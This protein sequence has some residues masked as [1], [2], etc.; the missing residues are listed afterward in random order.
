M[1]RSKWSDD[2][3]AFEGLASMT[4]RAEELFGIPNTPIDD[5]GGFVAPIFPMREVVLFPRMI[6][7]VFFAGDAELQVVEVAQQIKQTIIV[8]FPKDPKKKTYSRKTDF[9]PIS[10]E[11]ASGSVVSLPD[12]HYS[13]LLQ[14]RR[15]VKIL[16]TRKQDGFHLAYCCPIDDEVK[17]TNAMKGLIRST[18][19]LFERVVSLDRKLPD[20]SYGLA[21]SIDDPI[22]LADMIMTTVTIPRQDRLAILQEADPVKRLNLVNRALAAELSILEVES[23]ISEKVQDEVDKSQREFYLREQVKA[24]QKELNEED[25]FTRETEELRAKVAEKGFP[26]AVL[27]VAEREVD[28]LAA[29]PPMS[30]EITVSRT[31]LDWLLD[32]PWTETTEDN[33][34]VRNA[35]RVLNE[36]H[37]GLKKA[38]DRILEYIAVRS[39]KPK[40]ER[41]PILC[42]VGPPGTGKTSIGRSIADALG[43]E[44]V[45]ISLGG[46][47]DEAE[48]RGHRKTYVGALPGR[49]LQTIKRAG[50]I[51][52]LFMLD[53]IDKLGND[54]RGDPASALLEVLDPEQNNTFADHYLEVEYD[55]SK[56]MFVTTANSQDAI[57][58]PLL[59]RMEVIEFP[60]YTPEEKLIIAKDYLIGRQFDENG[61]DAN[62]L[63]LSD[64]AIRKLIREYT[65]EAGVRNLEREI[66]KICRKIARM[67][68]EKRAFP[69]VIDPDQVETL[70][71]PP[72]FFDSEKERQ[73]QVGVAT[74]LAWTE[75]GG[76]LTTIEALCFE[77]K[78]SLQLTGQLGEVMQESAQAALSYIKANTQRFNIPIS[79]YEKMDLHIHVPEGAV[80]KDGPSGGITLATAM[81]SALTNTPIRRD[82]AMT[83]EITLRGHVLP[84][85]GLKEKS[86]AALR[87]G[88]TTV[89]I[90]EKNLKDLVE[91]SKEALE[92]LTFIGVSTMDEVIP[93]AFGGVEPRAADC[94]PDDETEETDA[95]TD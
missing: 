54:Y 75:N 16:E 84:I 51:N 23:E 21:S 52:P 39:L 28:R 88:I 37:Y 44:F 55:L 27:A 50:T 2:E 66:G 91:L 40:K 73:D 11:A 18:K 32:L 90:P 92:R 58:T 79:R 33:L 15:R 12:D 31:Y 42:F 4:D 87:A 6:T 82:V 59:D 76:D 41:Q 56:V 5:A 72:Q 48:I 34:D 70:M 25:I 77:G 17:L 9:L 10:V 26:D 24:I 43:R 74:G 89:L 85:G 61:I 19:N 45:R 78:G 63:T 29:L 64:G 35:E 57:P 80:P 38:K 47:R 62:E 94:P 7:P 60:G 49:I 30:P 93:I 14:G 13:V 1:N 71:G 69:D 36:N 81:I 83:G 53:E 46:V 95:E 22:W 68:A 3:E 86:L 67:K 65:Y 20:E 8:A